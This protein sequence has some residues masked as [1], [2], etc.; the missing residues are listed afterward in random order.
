M[1]Q[2]PDDASR[3]PESDAASGVHC[4]TMLQVYCYSSAPVGGGDGVA[5]LL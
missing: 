3:V 2:E 4:C 5:V 1:L